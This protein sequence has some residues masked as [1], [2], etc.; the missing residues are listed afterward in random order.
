MLIHG[1]FVRLVV[2]QQR[3]S[4]VW[5]VGRDDLSLFALAHSPGSNV[6][7]LLYRLTPCCEASG[8]GSADSQTGVV[9]RNCY[10]SVS[11]EFGDC[12]YNDETSTIG[13]FDVEL[14]A[15]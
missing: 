4:E 10:K 6:V 1:T 2:P 15:S 3:S 5:V 9:C 7:G 11:H 12:D 8:K 13:T 14:A